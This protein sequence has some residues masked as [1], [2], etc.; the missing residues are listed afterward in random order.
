MKRRWRILEVIAWA[1]FFSVAA[2]VLVLRYGLLPQAERLRPE[3]VARVAATV[4]RPVTIGRIEAEWLGLR[5]QINL[6]DVRILD[7]EGREALVLPSVEN[8][9]SWRSLAHGRLRLH[10]L[11]IDGPKLAVRRDA[12]GAFYVAGITLA[13]F[14][15]KLGAELPPLEVASITGRLQGRALPDG[16]QLIARSVALAPQD[17]TPLAPVDFQLAWKAESGVVSANTLELAPLAHFAESLPLPTDIRKLALELEPRGQLGDFRFEWQGAF[18][19]PARYKARARFFDLGIKAR[20]KVPGF[21]K[22]AGNFEASEAGGRATLQSRGAQLE[23]PKVFPD[24]RLTFDILTGQLDWQ[25][26][27]AGMKVGISS[28][29]FANADLSGNAFG[30][31]AYGGEGPGV[32]DVSAVLN[33]ADAK[34]LPHYLPLGA[35]MGEGTRRWLVQG[36]LAGEASDVQVRL[37]GDLRDFPFT[38]PARGQFVVKAHVQHG[39]LNYAEGWPRIEEIDAD[40]SFERRRMDIVAKSG[41]ILGANVHE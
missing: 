7:A 25:R 11:R 41:R 8:I 37:Q 32:L 13:H 12:A 14:N 29:T 31:Y 23:L 1:T 28:V 9:L 2:A 15:A 39:L 10:A 6:S 20:E 24:P 3:I 35:L 40:L 33:R 18:E 26:E 22:L 17:G 5:P 4:G 34:N 19:A 36:I 16:Y 21:A 27:G 30:S 38:D